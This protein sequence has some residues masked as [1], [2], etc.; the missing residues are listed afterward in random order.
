MIQ[1]TS[2]GGLHWTGKRMLML[3]MFW[4]QNQEEKPGKTTGSRGEYPLDKP[5]AAHGLGSG[6]RPRA[7]PGRR[8]PPVYGTEL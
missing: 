5:P 1:A 6:M 8:W 3:E 4:T 2:N 7:R